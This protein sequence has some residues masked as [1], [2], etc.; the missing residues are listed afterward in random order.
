MLITDI[1]YNTWKNEMG[2]PENVSVPSIS[3]YFRNN[4][5][6][7]NNLLGTC[8]KLNTVQGSTNYLEI[9]KGKDSKCLIDPE[10]ASIYKYL[11]LISYYTRLIRN[12]TGVGDINLI[13][14]GSSDNGTVRFVDRGNLAK[15]YLQL[16][17]D[18]ESTMTRLVNKYKMHHQ[19][20]QQVTGD[21]IFVKPYNNTNDIPGAGGVLYGNDIY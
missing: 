5:Y 18:T 10:A 13:I 6:D 7:L 11:Y 2:E 3:A 14:Q 20:A 8:F 19:N 12:F 17:K 9:I 1:A 21:D 16:R 4:V 15:V